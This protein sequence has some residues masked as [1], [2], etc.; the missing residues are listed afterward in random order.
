VI[1][2]VPS[3]HIHLVPPLLPQRHGRL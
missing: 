2:A 3:V 1:V